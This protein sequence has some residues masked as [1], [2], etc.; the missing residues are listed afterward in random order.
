[1]ISSEP[2]IRRPSVC[3]RSELWKVTYNAH[4]L[5]A[6]QLYRLSLS[7]PHLVTHYYMCIHAF[8]IGSVPLL[9][10]V[11][12]LLHSAHVILSV[13]V[14]FFLPFALICVEIQV[15]MYM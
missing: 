2:E 8:V 7:C 5:V 1:M 4:R 10:F 3:V 6:G 13:A 12:F 14:Q 9:K 11:S 15:C